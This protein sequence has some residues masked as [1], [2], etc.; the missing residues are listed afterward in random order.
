MDSG[1]FSGL[2]DHVFAYGD[3]IENSPLGN[4]M[5]V[6]SRHHFG[7]F[8][9]LAA[10]GPAHESVPF[11]D[12]VGRLGYGH[13]FERSYGRDLGTSV[14]IES[15]RV[16]RLPFFFHQLIISIQNEKTALQILN[17]GKFFF[18]FS[19][20]KSRSIECIYANGGQVRSEIHFFEL[21]IVV[22][23]RLLPNLFD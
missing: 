11:L 14:G 9:I 1:T 5:D 22:S 21:E 17:G 13:S 6:A 15:D 19:V 4:E 12:R 7:E 3:R 20:V 10:L 16:H 18:S 23:E 8:I 2:N